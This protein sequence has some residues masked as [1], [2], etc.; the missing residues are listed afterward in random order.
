MSTLRILGLLLTNRMGEATEVQKI[1]T[2]YGCNI[3]TRL[4]MHETGDDFCSKKG[5]ILL[6]LT[7]EQKEWDNLEEELNQ[8]EGIKVQRM[9]FDW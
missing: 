9:H 4:G 5:I 3:K 7:G 1:L 6:E 2:K 8:V